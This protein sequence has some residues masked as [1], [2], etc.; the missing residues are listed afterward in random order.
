MNKDF[1]ICTVVHGKDMKSF[2]KNLKKAQ[3]SASMV[4]LRADSIKDFDSDD[5][6]ELI[7]H[8]KA[9]SIFT[10]R[11]KKEGG[12]FTGTAAKQKEILKQAFEFGFTYVD[13]A[14]NNPILK[15]LNAKEKKHLL[16]SYHNNKETPSVEELQGILHEMR[17]V[18]P[19]IIKIAT[20]VNTEEDLTILASLLNQKKKNEQLIVIGMGK[21]GDITRRNFPFMG[22]AIAYV[23]MKGD[24]S[25]APGM[26]TEEDFKS[27][28]K[29]LKK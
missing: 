23:K 10:F 1:Q 3:R 19:A 9:P 26:L 4:E 8:L 13:V 25:I 24:K 27:T 7:S 5:L 12:L 28:P 20:F 16:L 14:Y 6:S 2:L 21:K 18:K 11:H 29:Q 22:S 15:D 17:S